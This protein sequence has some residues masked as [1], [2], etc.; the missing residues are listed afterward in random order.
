MHYKDNCA[1][2]LGKAI[3]CSVVDDEYGYSQ[4]TKQQR[5]EMH[6]NKK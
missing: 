5:V 3:K 2:P 4:R 6:L 1:Q